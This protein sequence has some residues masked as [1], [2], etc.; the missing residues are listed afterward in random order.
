MTSRALQELERAWA[1]AH[2]AADGLRLTLIVVD[3][4]RPRPV[5]KAAEL[6]T[7]I[8]DL[9]KVGGRRLEQ[10]FAAG[11]EDARG[12]IGFAQERWLEATGLIVQ[13]ASPRSL[14][15]LDDFV[16][17]HGDQWEKWW[18][19]VLEGIEDLLPSV[20]E[21]D[22]ALAQCWRELTERGRVDIGAATVGTLRVGQVAGPA[23][24]SRR[25]PHDMTTRLRP[26]PASPRTGDL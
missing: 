3:E 10:T 11:D 2:A 23:E 26:V 19:P 15:D 24:P 18:P 20:H 6:V 12:A 25:D 21:T 22:V 14:F 16:Q 7:D 9:V 5:Q 4:P 13:L 1:A 8:T 17:R